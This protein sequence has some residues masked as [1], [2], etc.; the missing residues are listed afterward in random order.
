MI[1]LDKRSAR[2]VSHPAGAQAD[3]PIG[4][5]DREF[6]LVVTDEPTTMRSRAMSRKIDRTLLANSG[7][8]PAHSPQAHHSADHP[9]SRQSW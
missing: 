3:D 6:E 2:A 7:S 1:G 4:G 8:S 5:L 9:K